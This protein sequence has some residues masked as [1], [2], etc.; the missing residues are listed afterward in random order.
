[1]PKHL[2]HIHSVQT[3]DGQPKLPEPSM[4]NYGELAINYAKGYETISLKNN[5]D[6]V[7]QF[8]PDEHYQELLNNNKG[9]GKINIYSGET[10]ND[11]SHNTALA[12]FAHAEGG[13]C[14]ANGGYSHAEGMD[15]LSNG[16]ATHAEGT[17]T[18]ANG[19]QAHSEGL[20]TIANNTA[21]HAE[22]CYNVSHTEDSSYT[23]HSVGI[24]IEGERKNAHEILING[25][26]YIYG[27]GGYDGV[28]MDSAMSL[29]DIINSKQNAVDENLVASSHVVTEVINS[30]VADTGA[31]ATRISLLDREC[32]ETYIKGEDVVGNYITGISFVSATTKDMVSIGINYEHKGISFGQYLPEPVS[33]PSMIAIGLS[34]ATPS[35]AGVM[36]ATDK[37]KLDSLNVPESIDV[38]TLFAATA[39]VTSDIS[40]KIAELGNSGTT[41][42]PVLYAGPSIGNIKPTWIRTVSGITNMMCLADNK[43]YYFEISGTTVQR[44]EL[45]IS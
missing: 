23:I 18:T 45:A 20:G 32:E 37:Q 16:A 6:E 40:S 22:G 12:M 35:Q 44:A 41:E 14:Q 1:M 31:L 38:S 39:S 8:K 5:S 10:F 28:N 24:G 36:S 21:E 3:T 11:Y 4:L 13:N 27:I 43:I 19:D 30:L 29:Q 2:V 9:A 33:D 25:N 34:S 26:H 7:V 15:T 17:M 42:F